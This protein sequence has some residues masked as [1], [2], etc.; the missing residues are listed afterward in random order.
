VKN[1]KPTVLIGPYEND[2]TE[3]VSLVNRCFVEGLS[4]RYDFIP[5]VANRSF[6]GTRRSSF[7]VGN[8]IFFAKHFVL[9]I[10]RLI[11]HRPDIVHYSLNSGWAMEKSLAFLRVGRWFGA[12]TIAHLHSGSF[13]DFWARLSPARRRRAERQLAAL[14]CLVVLSEQW[15]RRVIEHLHLPPDKVRVVNNPLDRAFEEQALRMPI[16]REGN[17][18]LALGV[19]DTQKGVLDIIEAAALARGRAQFKLVLAGPEREPGIRAR[20]EQLIRAKNLTDAVELR[21]AVWGEEKVELFRRASAFLLPSYYENFPVVVLEAA[22]AGLPLVVSPVGATSEFFAHERSAWFVS[23]GDVAGLAEALVH[24]S[25]SSSLRHR[26]GSAARA[27]FAERLGRER[28]LTS[29]A[30]VYESLSRAKG[31]VSSP[32]PVPDSVL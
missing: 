10:A 4:E 7:N 15:K 32:R 25:E 31:F 13:L 14:D 26:L 6:G 30:S 3:S 23:P 24:V 1:G 12:R 29:L 18:I 16:E 8:L 21:D 5:H 22:A 2:P 20:V 19:M 11:R 17:V 9:W 27:I 28:I